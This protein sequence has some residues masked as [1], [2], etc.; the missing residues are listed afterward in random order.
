LN[1]LPSSVPNLFLAETTLTITSDIN[2]RGNLEVAGKSK[3]YLSESLGGNITI[4]GDL[5]LDKYQLPTGIDPRV[6]FNKRGM[7][8]TITVRG[9]VKLLG[10]RANI[11][12][13]EGVGPIVEPSPWTPEIVGAQL[14]FDAQDETKITKIGSIVTGWTNKASGGS[15]SASQ[16]E[17]DNQPTYQIGVLNG[18]NAIRFD[19]TNDFL[20]INHNVALNILAN[21]N[22]EIFSVVQTNNPAEPVVNNY[23]VFF[24]KGNTSA[25]DFIFY[26]A[27]N[28]FRI[29][30]DVNKLGVVA[31]NNH[32]TA[33][34]FGWARR[35]GATAYLYNTIGGYEERANVA[36]AT[37]LGN[38]HHVTIGAAEDGNLRF[39][40]GD[41]G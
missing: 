1:F 20:K 35:Q 18:K 32:S 26:V 31:P 37:M 17:P 19:G 2:V 22:F 10:V 21:Q 40:D 14:W 16:S 3:L 33:P 23:P 8:K 29:Y 6:L 12:I 38:S 4:G 5:I 9:D 24:G 11:G 27:I 13:N 30:M 7:P 36:H 39:H 25:N 15:Y 34:N 28:K 41:I